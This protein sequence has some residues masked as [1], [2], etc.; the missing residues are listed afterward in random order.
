MISLSYKIGA[1]GEEVASFFLPLIIAL[2]ENS[3]CS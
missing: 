2:F 3:T 1:G